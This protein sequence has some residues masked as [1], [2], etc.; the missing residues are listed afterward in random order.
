S[1]TG[2][3]LHLSFG[4]NHVLRGVDIQVD[5]GT[6]TTV[7]GPSGSGKSTLLRVLNRLHEPDQGDVLLDGRSVLRDNP[8]EL[9]RRI[10]MV[11]QH[12]NLFPHKTVVD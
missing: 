9:R 7:I 10:G 12:F 8:D 6:T 2:T 5:A 4:K 1:L 3:D 11:F